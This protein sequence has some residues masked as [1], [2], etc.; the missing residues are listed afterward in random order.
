MLDEFERNRDLLCRWIWVNCPFCNSEAQP[1]ISHWRGGGYQEEIVLQC[2][3]CG[4]SIKF[5]TD[6]SPIID[7][8]L[9]NEISDIFQG[10]LCPYLSIQKTEDYAYLLRCCSRI[11]NECFGKDP[12]NC[13]SYHYMKLK[14]YC[15]SGDLGK[16]TSEAE[17]TIKFSRKEHPEWVP[18]NGLFALVEIKHKFLSKA[19]W[20]KWVKTQIADA[21]KETDF[22]CAAWI[23]FDAAETYE[24]PEFWQLSSQLFD[25]YATKLRT[26]LDRESWSEK[27]KKTKEIVDTEIM[28]LISQSEMDVSQKPQLLKTVGDKWLEL[29][30]LS[31]DFISHPEFVY[32]ARYYEYYALAE[33]KDAPSYYKMASDFLNSI[34][35]K[36]Q[37]P[38]EKVYYEGHSKFFKGLH[39]LSLANLSSEE[40]LDLLEKSAKSFEEA[41]ALSQKIKL[42][43]RD[44]T[45]IANCVRAILCIE[46]F[47]HDDSN[48]GLVLEATGY[49]KVAKSY[50]LPRKNVEIVDALIETYSQALLAAETPTQAVLLIAQAR[51]KLE[52]FVQLLPALKVREIPVPDVLDFQKYYLKVYL[53]TIAK[54]VKSYA[55]KALSFNNICASLDEFRVLVESQLYHAFE[56]NNPREEIGRSLVQA[57]FGNSFPEKNIQ[58]REVTV[59]EGRSD[60]MLVVDMEKYPFEVKIWRGEEYY[61]KGLEQ[62]KYYMN[63]ENVDFGFYIIFDPR[64]EEYKSGCESI[65]YDSKRIYQVFIRIRPNKP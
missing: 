24:E 6:W 48:F 54:N 15:E 5:I 65:V 64:V 4:K 12:Q 43:A 29:Y 34:I 26:N 16:A 45:V 10:D 55:G 52:A 25:K 3:Q 30:R 31:G 40:R 13:A 50:G 53:D 35:D 63:Y 36:L 1:K 19:D 60:N 20:K 39:Y 17:M 28:S 21:E 41:I 32:K 2:P 49:L 37:Y 38:R 42:E 58:F 8:P 23:A 62:I 47:N 44:V 33:P 59:A 22:G 56:E 27:R 14:E 57:S 9:V 61:Q 18:P 51:K 46:K 11:R 7:P